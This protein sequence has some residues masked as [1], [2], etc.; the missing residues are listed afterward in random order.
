MVSAAWIEVEGID[1]SDGC[2]LWEAVWTVSGGDQPPDDVLALA[3]KL[4]GA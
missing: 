1:T 2:A 3:H 4:C